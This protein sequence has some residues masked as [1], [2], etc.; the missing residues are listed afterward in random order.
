M[1]KICPVIDESKHTLGV[2]LDFSGAFDTINYNILLNK[3][4]FYGIQGIS[5]E[6]GAISMTERN[7]DG[8]LQGSILGPLLLIISIKD[9]VKY[10]NI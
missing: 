8:V 2:F 9:L 7:I 6:W 4:A 3:L 10:S 5:L 1:D